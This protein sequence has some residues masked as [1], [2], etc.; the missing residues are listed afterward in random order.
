MLEIKTKEQ[1]NENIN[2]VDILLLIPVQ[3]LDRLVL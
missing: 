1:R 2:K 3:S